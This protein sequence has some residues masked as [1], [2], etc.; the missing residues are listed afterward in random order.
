M[1]HRNTAQS[2]Q[3]RGSHFGRGG[4]DSHQRGNNNNWRSQERDDEGRF[5]DQNGGEG[6]SYSQSGNDNWRSEDR[7]E[8]GRFTG[9]GSP[10]SYGDSG[11]EDAA[12]G[13]GRNQG[14]NYGF[15]RGGDAGEY[16]NSFFDQEPGSYGGRSLG[17]SGW[18][19][20]DNEFDSDYH[21]WR[22]EQI[23]KLDEDYKAW[24]GER[25]QKFSDE[26]GKWRSE[27]AA[28]GDSQKETQGKNGPAPVHKP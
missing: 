1:Q 8:R 22:N 6:R 11:D 16:R 13:L 25:R 9:Q 10:R 12:Y 27:R 24:Q 3:G 17:R 14:Q 23:G 21:H 4:R 26:F 18:Q 19:N 28:K 5:M 7:D 20:Q 2:H 15:G